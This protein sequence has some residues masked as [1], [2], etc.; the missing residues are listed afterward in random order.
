MTLNHLLSYFS[1]ADMSADQVSRVSLLATTVAAVITA[2]IAV[3]AIVRPLRY[4]KSAALLE[5]AK[6]SLERAYAALTLD[7]TQI[8]PVPAERLNWL[9]AARHIETYKALKRRIRAHVHRVM[10]DDHEEHW[11]HQFYLA[12]NMH[13]IHDA[14]YYREVRSPRAQR[15]SGLS[16]ESVIIVYGFATWPEGRPDPTDDADF[17][18]IFHSTDPRPGNIGLTTF[19]NDFP[20]FCDVPRHRPVP[21]MRWSRLRER[22][23]RWRRL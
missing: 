4:Q 16:P 1:L 3:L 2:F 15:R 23:R 8:R 19:L 17:A 11:R 20:Q 10:I 6:L 21:S 7:G 12:L 22:I 18:E 14:G 5:H 9:T 13:N